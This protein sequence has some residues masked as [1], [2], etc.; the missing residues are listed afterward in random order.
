MTSVGKILVF[1]NLL[2]SIATS[3]MIVLIY[4]SR[5]RY[6]VEYEKAKNVALVAE[7]AYKTEKQAHDNDVRNRDSQIDSLAK[8][9]QAVTTERNDLLTEKK[10]MSAQLAVERNEREVAQATNKALS[11]EL[12]SQKA[13]RDILTADAQTQRAKV[14]EVQKDLNDT[15]LLAVN[16]RIEADAQTQKARRLLDRVEE[17]ERN[18]TTLTNQI[19]SLGATAS[20]SGNSLLNPPAIPAPRDVRGTVRAVA[21]SGLTVVS[22]GSDSGISA[23]NK[24]YIM[25]IDTQNPANSLYL[26]ELVIS[27]VEPKQAVGQFYPKPFAKPDERLPKENDMVSTSMGSR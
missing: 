10:D 20:A 15:R 11:G 25:R 8:I 26:G 1:M 16:N 3:A 18:N 7:A 19:K 13:E 4:T 21:T 27:R 2:M 6:A 5:T 12:T 24:L 9:N 23:G 14:L 17:L 22:I